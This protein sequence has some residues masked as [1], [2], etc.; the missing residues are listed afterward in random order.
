MVE[1][2]P[3]DLLSHGTIPFQTEGRLLEELG[4]RL[5]ARPEVALVELIKNSY[6]ADSPACT[7]RLEEDNKALIVADEG[8]GMTF[9]DFQTRWMRIATSTKAK[10]GVSPAYHRKLT[11]A[12]GIGRFAV[13]YL[14]D[15]LTL[16]SVAFDKVHNCLTKLTAIFDW[17]KLEVVDDISKTSVRYELIRAPHSASAGTTL[18]IRQLREA[19]DFLSSQELRDNVLKM[20]SPIQGLESGKFSTTQKDKEIDPGFKVVLPGHS[21]AEDT[22]LAKFVLDNYW[23]RLTIELDKGQL[24]FCVWF[25]SSK[26]P[27]TLNIKVDSNIS[28]GLFADIRFFPRR[29]G[30]FSAKGVDGRTAWNWVRENFGVAVVDHGF[31]I[32][33]YGFQNDDWLMLDLHTAR[34]ER[35]WY[36]KIAQKYFPIPPAIK[37]EPAYNPMLN[38]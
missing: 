32:K 18:T 8:H 6:D 13:R 27:K 11:G 21:G 16:E 30:V 9:T 29:K 14:G 35:D 20:V 34:N 10:E 26:K 3:K 28:N 17:P 4:L 12:K 15:H 5:V 33:P 37:S 31:R 1:E 19:T 24:K 25:S 38:P 7:V 23:A 2:P 36:T 22:D